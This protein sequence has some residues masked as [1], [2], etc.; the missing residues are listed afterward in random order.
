VLGEGHVIAVGSMKEL[1]TMQDPAVRS[2]FDGTR[3]RAA[4]VQSK[5]STTSVTPSK[6]QSKTL[7]QPET[8]K[9]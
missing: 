5:T 2:Y 6:V 1:A 7:L 9:E 8:L 4:Q 3:A